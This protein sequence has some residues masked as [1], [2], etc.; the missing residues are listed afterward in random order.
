MNKISCVCCI[1]LGLNTMKKRYFNKKRYLLKKGQLRH[2]LYQDE[3]SQMIVLMGVTL[4]LSV[5]MMGSLAAEISGLEVSM[6]QARTNILLPEFIH[7]K[8]AFGL[9]LNYDLVDINSSSLAFE[10]EMYG[11]NISFPE[12]SIAV[13]KTASSFRKIELQHGRIFTATYKALDYSRITS[14]GHVYHVRVRLSLKSG[15]SMIAESVI[16]SIV[17]KGPSIS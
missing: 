6:P 9:A 1:G 4:A 7:I 8:E 14:M 12:I 11:D 2:T 5:L 10:G 16:Y 17:C 3:K 15:E 13:G